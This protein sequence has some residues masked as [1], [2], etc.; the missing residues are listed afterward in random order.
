MEGSMK[1]SKRGQITIPKRFRDQ[2]G[3]NCGDEVEIT[4]LKHGVLI[5]KRA[6]EQ[7]PVERVYGT[8][9]RKENV[10]EYIEDIRGR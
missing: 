3:M 2:Y 10:D 5:Q 6:E 9:C 7:H 1:V 8:L 4:P